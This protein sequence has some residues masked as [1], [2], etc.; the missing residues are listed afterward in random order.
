MLVLPTRGALGPKLL[1]LVHFS[2]SDFTKFLM[3]LPAT[4]V[5]P[6]N[7]YATAQLPTT[8]DRRSTIR[9]FTYSK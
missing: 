6:L 1:K 9:N 7:P 8:E 5:T 2:S 4:I 3:T